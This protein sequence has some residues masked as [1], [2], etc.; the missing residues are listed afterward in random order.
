MKTD[1]HSPRKAFSLVEILVATAALAV[2]S[3]LLLGVF[4]RASAS[5]NRLKCDVNLK[6]LSFALDAYRQENGY[7]PIALQELSQNEYVTDN[8]ILR[9]PADPTAKGTYGDF[10]V[11]RQPRD[12]TTLP[13]LV[14]PY[15][16]RD[17]E[18]GGQAYVGRYTTQFMTKPAT[19]VTANATTVQHP[20]ED[21]IAAPSGLVLHGA[22][23]LRTAKN[24]TAIIDFADGSRAMLKRGSEV[25]LLQC[26]L[27]GNSQ[28]LLYTLLR[29]TAGDV[30]YTVNKGS[31]FDVTTPAGTAGALGTKFQ[32]KIEASSDTTLLVTQGKV[33]FN[34]RRKNIQVTNG[35]PATAKK[36]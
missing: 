7:F 27:E 16:E 25:T 8:S 28:P 3:A 18:Q 2:L 13:I 4:G 22:D 14:C 23:V 6:S 10:Y 1:G 32:I 11:V 31:K 35:V 29:Q 17:H 15:H 30:T 34:N 36:Q 12:K 24:G 9:C 19:L 20:G 33:R 26:F 21:P 5:R